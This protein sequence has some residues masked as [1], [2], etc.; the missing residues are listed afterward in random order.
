[1]HIHTKKKRQLE[2]GEKM[3]S[4]IWDLLWNGP[5]GGEPKEENNNNSIPPSGP[6]REYNKIPEEDAT[7]PPQDNNQQQRKSIFFSYEEGVYMTYTSQAS[8]QFICTPQKQCC[9]KN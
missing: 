8:F 7:G 4:S 2:W 5:S 3:A 1:M 6:R 9:K